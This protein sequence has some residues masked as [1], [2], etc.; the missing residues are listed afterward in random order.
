MPD[1]DNSELYVSQVYEMR[2][3]CKGEPVRGVFGLDQSYLPQGVMMYSGQDPLFRE[4]Q[5]HRCWY[6]WGTRYTDGSY[7]S[8][9]FVLG[10][11]RVGFALITDQDGYLILDTDVTGAIELMEDNIWPRRIVVHTSAGE[12]EFLPDPKGRMPD[13]LGNIQSTTPQNEG[14][15][16][17][18]GDI[19]QPAA[20]FAWGEVQHADKIDYTKHT[21]F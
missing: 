13:L 9:H 14:R 10:T 1:A 15:W 2:G 8:G 18:I 17:R 6:T 11:D 3:H 20:W 16:Q 21:R 12:F 5:H 7:Q 4:D 19:R